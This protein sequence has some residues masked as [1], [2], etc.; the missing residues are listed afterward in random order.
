M[1]EYSLIITYTL[2][3]QEFRPDVET[4]CIVIQEENK[5]N[6][7]LGAGSLIGS[8]FSWINGELS[9]YSGGVIDV[10][11]TTLIVQD[12]SGFDYNLKAVG[13]TLGPRKIEGREQTN[14][15]NVTPDDADSENFVDL[16]VMLDPIPDEILSI[17]K[18]SKKALD[19]NFKEI[20]GFT[21]SK[22]GDGITVSQKAYCSFSVRYLSI[23]HVYS[24]TST[25]TSK[26]LLIYS[27][28]G[29]GE[30]EDFI[31]TPDSCYGDTSIV[32]SGDEDDVKGQDAVIVYDFCTKELISQ[33]PDGQ[34]PEGSCWGGRRWP[35]GE[36]CG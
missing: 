3:Q 29:C 12:R 10:Y 11:R 32:P 17:A 4:P 14:I 26:E 28:S 27:E 15:V 13:G 23:L 33:S 18:S 25:D 31:L 21:F 8:M 6:C 9:E 19:E 16:S 20:F 35:S 36:K 2:G 1:S 34:V 30:I 5:K 22:K 7:G 24:F